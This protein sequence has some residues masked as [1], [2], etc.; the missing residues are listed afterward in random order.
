MTIAEVTTY[1]ISGAG[2]FGVGAAFVRAWLGL[3]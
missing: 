2:S 1:L 3:P